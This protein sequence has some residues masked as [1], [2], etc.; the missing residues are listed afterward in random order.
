[1]YVILRQSVVKLVNQFSIKIE[2]LSF[3]TLVLEVHF[4]EA[5]KLQDL[6]SFLNNEKTKKISTKNFLPH[7]THFFQPSRK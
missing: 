6:L 5:L 3:L 2:T 1:M 4:L 7:I